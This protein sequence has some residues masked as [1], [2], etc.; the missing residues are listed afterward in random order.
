[1]KLSISAVFAVAAARE[2][3]LD[4]AIERLDLIE[5]KFEVKRQNRRQELT[6][7]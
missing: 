6:P 1:M 2:L 7:F 3:D 4:N 5:E